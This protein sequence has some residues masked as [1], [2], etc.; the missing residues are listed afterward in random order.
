MADKIN[1]SNA[2]STLKQ[3]STEVIRLEASHIVSLYEIDLSNIKMNLNLGPSANDIAPDVLRFHNEEPLSTKAILFRGD[4]Y[5]PMPIIAGGF[6]VNSNG[7]LP[8]PTLSISSLKGILSEA[9]ANAYF[10]SLKR[11]ILELDN[12]IGAKVSR[13]RTFYKFLDAANDLDGVGDFSGSVNPEFPKEIYYVERKVSEDKE[14]MQ[15]ELSSVLDLEN[16][17]LP[18]RL[19]VASRCTWTYRGEGCCYEFK[20]K[21]STGTHGA[22]EHLPDFAPPIANDEDELISD[23]ISNYDSGSVKASD[24]VEFNYDNTVTC[25]GGQQ[26]NYCEGSIV[27][28][29]KDGINY[30][31]V[32]KK[33]VP[34]GHPPPHSDYWEADRCSKSMAGCRLRWGTAGSAKS[35]AVG[36]CT[37]EN[38]Q[39]R[40]DSGS[41]EGQTNDLLPFGGFP[42]TNSKYTT[43]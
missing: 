25:D 15:F 4:T 38:P 1:T 5:H 31:Y 22:T 11:A 16:F 37:S 2:Q 19:C 33:H 9:E 20:T 6:E 12:M 10:N 41:C 14:G 8:R 30:Y 3:I 27:Y 35:C 18:G 32:A 39:G 28:I 42:G 13:I 21:G 40:C 29:T 7:S 36:T 24:V 26:Y 43:Q 23:V 34:V 17:K